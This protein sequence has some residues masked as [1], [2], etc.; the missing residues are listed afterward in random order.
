ME[1]KAVF[2][3]YDDILQNIANRA[4]GSVLEFEVGTGN[5]TKKLLDNGL[6]VLG[7]EP[8]DRV[9]DFVWIMEA[10]KGGYEP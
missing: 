3:Y 8:S 2:K 1:Y 10:K 4:Y 6:D 9:N 5:L 7:I